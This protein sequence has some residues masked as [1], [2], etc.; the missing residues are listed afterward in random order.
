MK[1]SEREYWTTTEAAAVMGRS[2]G[3]WARMFDDGVVRGYKDRGR[4]LQADSCRAHLERLS[5]ERGEVS[6]A[7]LAQLEARQMFWNRQRARMAGR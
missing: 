2:A 6:D 3:Y 7:K 4:H 1:L 5:A